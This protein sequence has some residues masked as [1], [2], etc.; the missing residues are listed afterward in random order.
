MNY[1][2]IRPLDGVPSGMQVSFILA[3]VFLFGDFDQIKVV[4]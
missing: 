4:E 1:V 2:Q 3:F